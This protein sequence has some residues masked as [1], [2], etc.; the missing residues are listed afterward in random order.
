MSTLIST[1]SLSD[2][3]DSDCPVLDQP[4]PSD[5]RVS[6]TNGSTRSRRSSR[7]KRGNKKPE[8]TEN[9][10]VVFG[11]LE[12]LDVFKECLELITTECGPVRSHYFRD[13]QNCGF[14]YF[15]DEQTAVKAKNHFCGYQLKGAPLKALPPNEY[16]ENNMD[17]LPVPQSSRRSSESPLPFLSNERLRRTSD[18]AHLA[19]L[20]Q[21]RDMERG[22]STLVLKNLNFN[23]QHDQL[24]D[25]MKL[26]GAAPHTVNYS[27]DQ[28]GVFRGV[29]FAKYKKVEDATNAMEKLSG[30]DIAGR[31][32]RIEFKRR[33]SSISSLT[34]P[35]IRASTSP[36]LVGEAFDAANMDDEQKMIMGQLKALQQNSGAQEMNFPTTFNMGQRNQ[37]HMIAEH[38]KLHHKTRE[39]TDG[40][41]VCVSKQPFPELPPARRHS[42]MGDSRL[43]PRPTGH[44]SRTNSVGGSLRPAC[45][46]VVQPKGPDGSR[47][48]GRARRRSMPLLQQN[49]KAPG[50]PSLGPAV[51]PSTA[52]APR[53][54]HV[55]HTDC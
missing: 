9:S 46:E 14:V 16:F 39:G 44:R 21:Q 30:L 8:R 6:E 23:L 26:L 47:G 34:P 37:V 7:T 31:K 2:L 41:Y 48:F 52:P 5:R 1:P 51:A 35:V 54:S 40:K 53:R 12:N 50:S 13:Y 17:A 49:F 33:G 20:G 11:P 25:L 32:L 29:A 24:V 27:Y 15:H 45:L 55:P 4:V 28:T 36:S 22:A 18:V 10:T 43:S 19:V 38:L 42:H 3:P